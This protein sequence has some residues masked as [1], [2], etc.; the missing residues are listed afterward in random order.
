MVNTIINKAFLLTPVMVLMAKL[1]GI[2]AITVSQP[3]TEDLTALVLLFVYL[4]VMKKKFPARTSGMHYKPTAWFPAGN[5]GTIL[6]VLY[7]V[8]SV[9]RR[10]KH[11]PFVS[12]KILRKQ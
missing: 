10:S 9:R 7:E 2:K 6:C 12:T 11:N 5:Y 8:S 1:I 3:I 4:F